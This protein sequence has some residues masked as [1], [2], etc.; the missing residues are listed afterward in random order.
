MQTLTHSVVQTLTHSQTARCGEVWPYLVCDADATASQVYPLV[1]VQEAC[2]L[3]QEAGLAVGRQRE[4]EASSH[5]H[6]KLRQEGGEGGRQVSAP[7]GAGEDTSLS[8]P[9]H[10][11][12]HPPTY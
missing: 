11:P 4:G 6:Q 9:T 5:T 3:L 8:N 10:P 12:T 7:S 2:Q 1:F